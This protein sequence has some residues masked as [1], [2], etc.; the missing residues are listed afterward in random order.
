VRKKS[1]T[2]QIREIQIKTTLRYHFSSPILAKIKKS[3][4]WKHSSNA[5]QALSS[6]PSIKGKKEKFENTVLEWV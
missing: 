2:S 1:S 5:E 6:N 3:E 4:H